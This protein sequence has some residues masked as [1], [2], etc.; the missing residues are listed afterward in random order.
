MSSLHLAA[1]ADPCVQWLRA[2]E[3]HVERVEQGPGLPRV[4]IRLS[5]LCD[6]FDGIAHAYG[7]GLKS[8]QRYCFVLRCGCEVRWYEGAA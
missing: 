1:Q 4:I 6:A 7:R 2:Q 8:E 3:L 5:P